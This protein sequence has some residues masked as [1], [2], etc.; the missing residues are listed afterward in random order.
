MLPLLLDEVSP[1]L[2]VGGSTALIVPVVDLAG[3]PGS[4]SRND[5]AQGSGRASSSR[6]DLA[7]GR[8]G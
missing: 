7:R 6:D 8:A 4:R 1:G 5:D 3:K 2:S